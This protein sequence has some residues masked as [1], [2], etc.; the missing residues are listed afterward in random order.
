MTSAYVYMTFAYVHMHT[1]IPDDMVQKTVN[2]RRDGST[3]HPGSKSFK[4]VE[5]R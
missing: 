4:W 1:D 2:L 5:D 3:Q